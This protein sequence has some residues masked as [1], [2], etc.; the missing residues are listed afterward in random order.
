M[1]DHY[2]RSVVFRCIIA[3]GMRT[4]LLAVFSAALSLA[5]VR[6]PALLAD[7]M[8]VQRGMPVH[9]W[10]HASPGEAVTVA[11]RGASA[12]A[13]ADDIG[14]WSLYLPPAQPGGPF[15]MEVRGANTI[16][17]TDVLVGDVWVASGQSNMEFAVKDSVGG[18]A[19]VAAANHPRIRLLHVQN[20]VAD[21]PLDDVVVKHP[22]RPCSPET[23]SDFSAV[24]YYFGRDLY[25]RDST[26]IG[27]IESS[28]GGTPAESWTSLRALSADAALM[29]VFAEWSKMADAL[30]AVKARRER[31]LA[32]WQEAVAKAKQE[33]RTPPSRPWQANDSGEW[34]PASLFNAMIAP[35]TPFA[36][37]GVIWYQGEGNATNERADLYHRLFGTMIQDWRRAWGIGDFPFLFVQLAN[38]KTAAS[39]RWPEIREAQRKTL[40]LANTAMAVTI[41]IGDPVD[42]HPKN[43]QGVGQRLALAARSFAGSAS[44]ASGPLFRQAVPEAGSMRVWFDHTGSG[45]KAKAGVVTG[46]EVAGADRV[47][48]PAEASIEGRTVVVSSPSVKAPS[49]VRYG[50]KDN[51]DATLYNGEGL[52]A[53]PFRSGSW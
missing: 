17:L 27:L 37:K 30:I 47:F 39:A 8:V 26:P 25:Q 48:V 24:A 40:S 41:D 38:F 18:E 31:Q 50:W 19:E 2:R 5:D 21:H 10:G 22:W 43:K 33:G 52:P 6:L 14:A 12:S 15:E 32:R 36:I 46:F 9:V 42:I 34:V 45:L 13:V 3:T 29:P 28:W 35:L 16:R 1:T 44:E 11:F 51:P 49:F 4:L 7:H 20:S 23:V 53:S